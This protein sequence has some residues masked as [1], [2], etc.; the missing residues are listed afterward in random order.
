MFRRLNLSA[1]DLATRHFR[2]SRMRSE[3]RAALVG[4]E[5]SRPTISLHSKFSR[6]YEGA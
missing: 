5:V 2:Q 4:P 3:G 1:A 6:F